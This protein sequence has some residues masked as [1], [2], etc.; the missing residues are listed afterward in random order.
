MLCF[1]FAGGKAE[2][3]PHRAIYE[4]P[5]SPNYGSHWAK[6]PIS[7]AKVKL[8]NKNSTK[9][10]IM[11]NSLHKYEPRL[12]ICK[13]GSHG[14][15]SRNPIKTIPFPV[16]QFIAVT[17][18]QNEEVTSLKIKYN[19]FAKA[20]LDARD[21]P[22]TNQLALASVNIQQHQQQQQQQQQQQHQQMQQHVEQNQMYY[23]PHMYY[24]HHPVQRVKE[25]STYTLAHNT[26][27]YPGYEYYQHFQQQHQQQ[28]NYLPQPQQ[29]Q[30]PEQHSP[31]SGSSVSP[32]SESPP[33]YHLNT[34]SRGHPNSEFG[35][36]DFGASAFAAAF[37]SNFPP[38]PNCHLFTSQNT[39]TSVNNESYTS[40]T[41]PTPPSDS[42]VPGNVKN[43]PVTLTAAVYEDSNDWLQQAVQACTVQ[44]AES[45]T[46]TPDQLRVQ[47]SPTS[48]N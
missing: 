13:V 38:Y 36:L 44:V 23:Q 2:P 43:E 10:K 42:A 6:E 30:Q 9:D 12:H 31:S 21:R 20:F 25:E 35:G 28:H 7:F 27:D 47:I 16:T 40:T 24:L 26:W 34:S 1:C 3:P 33:S 32:P 8:T 17:A 5:D 15:Q 22:Q 45:G 4:H 46:G 39:P 29:Q 41:L 11:L 19:P 37:S 48:S 14:P 18:Y